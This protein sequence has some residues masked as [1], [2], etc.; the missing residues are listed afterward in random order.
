MT[1]ASQRQS[2][3]RLHG[4]LRRAAG[5]LVCAA[6]ALALSRCASAPPATA[7]A[8]KA[9]AVPFDQKM[10]WIL[11][12]EDQRLMKLET[13]A[14]PPLPPTPP[15]KG[16]KPVTAPVMVAPPAMVPDLARLV[17][18]DEPRVRRRAALA[19]GRVGLPEGIKPLVETLADP[20]ADVRSMAAF[21]AGLVAVSVLDLPPALSKV[22]AEAGPPL[23]AAL[24][25]Q[26]PLVRGRAAEALGQLGA[27]E[28]AEPIGKMTAEYARSP[29]VAAMRPDDE[30]SATAGEVE[31]FRLGLFALVRLRTYE[32]LAAAI[33]DSGGRPTITGGLRPGAL[34]RIGDPRAR[35]A[36]LQLLS[37][38]Q[39]IGGLRG[40]WS[41]RDHDPGSVDALAALIAR[42]QLPIE[43]LVAAI[44]RSGRSATAARRRSC[45]CSRCRKRFPTC[46]SS[47]SPRSARCTPPPACHSCRTS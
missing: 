35:P 10:A 38:R 16:R 29:A 23:V 34:Q 44:R 20:D 24:A 22:Q 14:P 43:P 37:A 19:I 33:L 9:P 39:L 30:P 8:P 46:G 3:S 11:R 25:D 17:H 42:G 1:R 28:A 45:A 21:A 26:S 40:A 2:P 31:A 41:R 12:L 13:P 15:A 32:P 47:A 5:A 6:A 27:K 4:R 7:P 36:L 18:D